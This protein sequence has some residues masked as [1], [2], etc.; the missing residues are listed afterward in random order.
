[1]VSVRA[2]VQNALRRGGLSEESD[3]REVP[4]IGEYLA[5]RMTQAL[6]GQAPITVGDFW[7]ATGKMTTRKLERVLQRA[8]QNRRR[9]QCVD[10]LY[11]TSDINYSG[12]EACIAL[13]DHNRQLHHVRHGSLPKR[14][15][16]RAT[17]SKRCGCHTPDDCRSGPLCSLTRDGACV[18]RARNT[19]GFVGV[20]PHPDQKVVAHNDDA[21][22][23]VRR[24][25]HTRTT[26]ALMNDPASASDLAA[27]HGRT[28][29]YTVHGNLMWRRPSPVTRLPLVFHHP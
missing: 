12:Y 27:G 20:A 6:G 19:K 5:L 25:A 17:S 29:Q 7:T 16:Q 2:K 22:R 28:L 24:R 14:L 26:A 8:L 15:T 10:V 23:S 3:F 21:R 18:P 1:M 9:N 13:V 4:Y 11:H